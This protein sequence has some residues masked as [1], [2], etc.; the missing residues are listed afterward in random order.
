MSSLLDDLNA[1]QRAAVT[2]TEGPVLVVAGPGTGKTLTIVRRIACLAARGVPPR[3]ICAITF[4][5]RAAREMAER[6]RVLLGDA[7]EGVF[8]GTFH[9][10]G[11][12]ILRES[13]GGDLRLCDREE[14][15]K[16]LREVLAIPA[17]EAGHWAER[18]SRDKNLGHRGNTEE[19]GIR[20]RYDAALREMKACDF[21]DL[22]LMPTE[23]VLRQDRAFQ[24]PFA[25]IMVD[26][27]QDIS[28]AQ[29]RFLLALLGKGRNLCAVG[30]ADQAIYGF[31]G[32]D[33]RNFLSFQDDFKGA[34]Q[35][36]LET[37][38][39]STEAIVAAAGSL[40]AHNRKR[41]EKRNVAAGGRGAAIQL[42]SVPD[43]RAEGEVIV[44]E[45]E[46]RMGG[47]SH[48][49]LARGAAGR[50]GDEG[51][52]GFG[53]FAVLCRTNGHAQAMGDLFRASGI[54]YQVIGGRFMDRR[55]E[56]LRRLRDHGPAGGQPA[57]VPLL[58][59]RVCEEMGIP[60]ED[61]AFLHHLLARFASL[62][63]EQVLG[64]VVNEL[65]L[66]TPAD[67]YD[68]RAEAVSIMTLHMSKGLEFRILFVAG[69][70]EG[71]MPF[72]RGEGEAEVEEERR[73]FYVAMTRAREELFLVHARN[74]YVRGRRLARTPSRFLREIP[75]QW[76]KARVLP[77]RPKR[78]TGKQMGLFGS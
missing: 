70:E 74:R 64:G 10:L 25:Y 60:P 61:R 62:P 33:E 29:Y 63:P 40:I 19:P 47:T 18:I 58:L 23:L 24:D 13:V 73:L 31:R 59:D 49:G 30:D 8:I 75:G 1:S 45:I 78:A 26:E 67:I 37:N 3:S 36:V 32:A 65:A 43:E 14:Q 57:D 38:Y 22:I 54:P 4:T 56:V 7:G 6:A 53:D 27:Y 68:P 21:D 12:T 9:L 2:T 55:R 28:P 17:R 39:R 77:D 66:L 34:E 51:A 50:D 44:R 16:I 35:I 69:V 5:N 20:T 46:E 48:Y 42:L 76:V 11:L 15:V 71:L 41:I 52:Y 72:L